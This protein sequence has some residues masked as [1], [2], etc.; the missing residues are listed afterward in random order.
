MNFPRN[1]PVYPIFSEIIREILE[2]RAETY[3]KL[4]EEYDASRKK[5]VTDT[6]EDGGIDPNFINYEPL[7]IEGQEV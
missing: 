3:K 2:N 6:L 4:G 1:T 5:P 7:V